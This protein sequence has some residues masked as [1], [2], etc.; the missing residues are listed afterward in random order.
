MAKA[1]PPIPGPVDTATD[2]KWRAE[3]DLRCL[4]QAEEIKADKARMS[5]VGKLAQKQ[6]S[7]LDRIADRLGKRGLISDKAAKR[8]LDKDAD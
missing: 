3:S 8:H 7:D 4:M 2:Q 6:S 5:A 1:K